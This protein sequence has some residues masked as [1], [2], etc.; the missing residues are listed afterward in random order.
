[1]D[2][3]DTVS[4]LERPA[5]RLLNAE[6]AAVLLSF[7]FQGFKVNR[8]V[9]VPEG[10]LRGLVQNYIESLTAMGIEGLRENAV[11]YLRQTTPA[12][13]AYR[14]GPLLPKHPSQSGHSLFCF[15]LFFMLNLRSS[16]KV[17]IVIDYCS[18]LN[19]SWKMS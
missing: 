3:H 6:N 14:R 2:Y 10:E 16:S 15:S 13:L 17:N 11:S 12:D 8:R 19:K 18:F 1:M 5:V 7:L 9:T 4:L